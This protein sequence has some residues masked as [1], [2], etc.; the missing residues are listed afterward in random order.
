MVNLCHEELV[1]KWFNGNQSL[2]DES[3]QFCGFRFVYVFKI[4]EM[5]PSEFMCMNNQGALWE[6]SYPKGR[7]S[8]NIHLTHCQ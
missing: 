4:V 6:V 2:R 5:D 3:L 8:E 7:E 1:S